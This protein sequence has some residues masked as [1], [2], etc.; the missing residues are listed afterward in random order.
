MHQ[1]NI[2]DVRG[3]RAGHATEPIGRTGC[4]ALVFEGG[5][6]AGVDVRGAA[7]GTRET[8]LLKPGNTVENVHAILL[9]GGSAFGLDAASGAMRY[10]EERGIGFDT[11]V[12]RVPIVPAAVLFDLAV[13]SPKARPDAAMGYAACENATDRPLAQGQVGAGCGATVGKALGSSAT[14]AG[15]VGTASIQLPDGTTVAAV[16]AVNAFG[17]VVDYRSGA[18]L[19]GVRLPDGTFPGTQALLVGG[20]L[21]DPRGGTNTTIGVVATD[22]ALTKTEANRLATVAHDGLA[23]SIRPVHTGLDGDTLFAVSAGERHTEFNALCA[24]AVEVV[25]RAVAN[26]VEATCD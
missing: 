13:G 1:G 24:A 25:A 10:L 5:A 20:K 3:I 15:G 8:D 12:A 26:A 21:H 18:I 2:T 17:D 9:C 4:T 23:W 19:A 16:V 7:P 22:A 11:G 6:V 14:M